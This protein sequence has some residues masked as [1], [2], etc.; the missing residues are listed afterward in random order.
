MSNA[1]QSAFVQATILD[2]INGT[3]SS[4]E[5]LV[6]DKG[7]QPA[8]APANVVLPR[9]AVVALWF[10]FNGTFLHLTGGTAA[11]SLCQRY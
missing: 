10:G 8:A 9:G 6:I 5:P 11:G 4:Y 7:T 2:P 3:L 1:A